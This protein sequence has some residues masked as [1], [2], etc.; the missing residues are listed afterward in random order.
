MIDLVIKPSAGIPVT[1]CGVVV[2]GI[3]TTRTKPSMVLR[4]PDIWE[5]RSGS[6][7]KITPGADKDRMSPKC[8]M[9]PLN[10]YGG[11]DPS[12]LGIRYI[13]CALSVTDKLS[14]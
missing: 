11:L 14:A 6:G 12:I 7:F 13:N 3:E 10:L 5:I 2:T 1:G 4:H 9:V 8:F